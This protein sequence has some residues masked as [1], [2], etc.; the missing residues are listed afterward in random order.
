MS[1]AEVSKRLERQINC[2]KQMQAL[3]VQ[4]EQEISRYAAQTSKWAEYNDVL[5]KTS[6]SNLELWKEYSDASFGMITRSEANTFSDPTAFNS[7]R[8]S[9]SNQIK[10]LEKTQATLE[11]YAEASESPIE[12]N[13]AYQAPAPKPIEVLTLRPG[14]WGINIDL[15]E[16]VRRCAKWWRSRKS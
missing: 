10:A 16:A 1:R 7:Y 8:R 3:S 12:K 14:M 11:L 5:L 2:G 9:I 6:F 13:A 4:S 15:K